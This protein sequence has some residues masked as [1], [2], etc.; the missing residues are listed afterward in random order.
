MAAF[1]NVVLTNTFDVWRIR[2]NDLVGRLNNISVSNSAIFSNTVTA[3]VQLNVLGSA[4]VAGVFQINTGSANTN[5]FSDH[6][7][8]TS[9]TQIGGTTNLR[10]ATTLDSTLVV[11]GTSAFQGQTNV[12]A[13]FTVDDNVSNTN[14]YSDHLNVTSNAQFTGVTNFSGTA[15]A[16]S[17]FTVDPGVS[18]TNIYSDHLNVTS[19]SAFGGSAEFAGL[20][21]L[22]GTANAQ[23][24]LTV[25]P[26]VSNTNIYSDHMNVTANVNMSGT[27]T[28]A[29]LNTTATDIAA[30]INEVNDNAIAFAIALG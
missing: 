17:V 25:D 9:N 18:N 26:G 13:R 30:A 5:I 7:N 27:A 19:N 23:S 10:G 15:N 24:V 11:A 22:A 16:Q 20:V 1:A 12:S 4:N 6:F 21:N 29:G 3:N 28:L 2:T 14:I 8:V